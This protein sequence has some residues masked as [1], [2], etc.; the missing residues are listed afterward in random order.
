MN[1]KLYTIG[2]RALITD[3]IDWN[4]HTIKIGLVTT[5]SGYMPNMSELTMD[6]IKPFIH[7]SKKLKNKTVK[8]S[9]SCKTF[10]ADDVVFEKVKALAPIVGFILYCKEFNMPIAYFHITE[11]N[12]TGGNLTINFSDSTQ[13]IIT[14]R[15][16]ILFDGLKK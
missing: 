8:L 3:F 10:D 11:T 5:I 2:E 16:Q 7:K 12:T 6:N 15:R 1:T 4:S 9:G 14:V 13:K